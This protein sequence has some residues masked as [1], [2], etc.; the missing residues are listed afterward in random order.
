MPLQSS[1]K[2]PSSL[3]V[4]PTIYPPFDKEELAQKPYYLFFGPHNESPEDGPLKTSGMIVKS[5]GEPVWISVRPTS[6][7]NTV[8]R[9]DSFRSDRADFIPGDHDCGVR[10]KRKS[11]ISTSMSSYVSQ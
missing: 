8:T 1:H 3:E 9:Y 7:L 4:E 11:A 6:F 10:R 2:F 5:T